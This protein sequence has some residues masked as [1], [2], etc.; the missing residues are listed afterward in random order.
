LNRS[1]IEILIES[2]NKSIYIDGVP[3]TE[4]IE[5]ELKL[6]NKELERY[7][8]ELAER[9]QIVAANKM[10]I[11]QDEELVNS[12]KNYIKERGY[13]LFMIS[14][15]AGTG[16]KE[17]VKATASRLSGLPPI[18]VF[19]A[20]YVPKQQMQGTPEDLIIE[21]FDDVW[22]I[23]GDWIERLMGNVNFSDYE[24]RMYFDRVLRNAGVFKRLEEM[25]IQDGDTIS[26]YDVEFEYT[27]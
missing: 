21:K 20:D 8:P 19:E 9:P 2:L 27:E 14:A 23:E 7:S 18:T 17:L 12:F 6:L 11:A 3:Y 15:A 1:V 24:S 26:I 10:D 4:T 22:T 5:L 25:G 13:E 16:V